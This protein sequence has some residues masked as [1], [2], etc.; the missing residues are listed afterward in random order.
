MFRI[1]RTLFGQR[2]KTL[3]KA[4]QSLPEYP[5][6]ATVQAALERAGIDPGLRGE[7]LSIAEFDAIARELPSGAHSL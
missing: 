2:R 4:L 1:S 7:R 6:R 3:L 5:A